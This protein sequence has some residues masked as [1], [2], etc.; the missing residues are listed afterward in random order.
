MVL[1]SVRLKIQAEKGRVGDG[2]EESEGKESG[3][4]EKEEEAEREG[5]RVSLSLSGLDSVSCIRILAGSHCFLVW[6]KCPMI[7]LNGYSLQ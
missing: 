3:E 6:V 7:R 1:Q 2:D 4:R 5:E